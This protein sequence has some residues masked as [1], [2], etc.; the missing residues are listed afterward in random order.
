MPIRNLRKLILALS[1]PALSI[2]WAQNDPDDAP[3]PTA[4]VHLAVTVQGDVDVS[5]WTGNLKPVDLRQLR[6]AALPCDWRGESSAYGY[7][8]GACHRMIPSDGASVRGGIPVAGLV[9]ALR[10]LGAS[11][12]RLSLTGFEHFQTAPGNGWR[13]QQYTLRGKSS[14]NDRMYFYESHSMK[15]IPLVAAIRIGTPWSV[16]RFA[17]PLAVT[18]FAPAILA[19]WLRRRSE[20]KGSRPSVVVWLNWLLNGMFLYWITAGSSSDLAAL[21]IRLHIESTVLLVA[22]GAL[23]FSIPPLIAV[24]SC[25]VLMHPAEE[26]TIAVAAARGA[27]IQTA[28]LLVPLGIFIAGGEAFNLDSRVA[29][30]SLLAAYAAYKMMAIAAAR[31]THGNIQ[32]L[33]QGALVQRATEI[34]QRAGVKLQGLY[35]T[36]NRARREANAFAAG[37]GVVMLSRGL[38]ENLTW[39]EVDSVMS[40]EIGHLRGKHTLAAAAGFWIYIVLQPIAFSVAAAAKVPHWILALPILPVAYIM[41]TAFLS[42]GREFSA[43]KRSVEL[44]GDPE[45]MIASLARLRRLTDSPVAWGGMQGS[46]LSH[47]S[48]QARVLAIARQFR[49]DEGRALALLDN[50]DLLQTPAAITPGAMTAPDRAPFPLHYELPQRSILFSTFAK[51]ARAF[52]GRWAM[53]AV[54][55]SELFCIAILISQ[56]SWDAILWSF[57]AMLAGIVLVVRT[58]LGVDNFLVCRFMKRIRRALQTERHLPQ[59][60][61]VFVGLL[62]GEQVALPE[63]YPIWDVGFLSFTPDFLTYEGEQT[64]FSVPRAEVTGITVQKGPLSWTP[65]HVVTVTWQGGAFSLTRPDLGTTYSRKARRLRAQLESWW[66]GEPLPQGLWGGALSGQFPAPA[67]PRLSVNL[68][69]GWKAFRT[70]GLRAFML[71]IGA[72]ILL[73]VLG[74]R[75]PGFATAMV[76]LLTPVCYLLAVCPLFFRRAPAA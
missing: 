23:A 45:G 26:R 66:R 35:L 17:T 7:L 48:M 50:P 32:I 37:T 8:H 53:N 49:V 54:L 58:F 3:N 63:G 67:L 39:R 33:T 4:S 28:V 15:E 6:A 71:F 38:V 11:T 42:R 36:D 43:D 65:H 59:G 68:F 2:C 34:A 60:E 18:L 29:M 31:V 27:T 64:A 44:T 12:V 13:L 55:V 72:I 46:I 61:G 52:W 21:G 19:L 1:L 14:S 70:L 75:S 40:H 73:Q 5:V 22:I 69:R 9:V 10:A 74:I 47:P 24:A 76:P 30:G 41:G 56:M 20:R 51:E 62:P 57:L 16:S 25:T